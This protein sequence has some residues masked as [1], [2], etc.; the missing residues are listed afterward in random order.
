MA[1]QVVTTS[2]RNEATKGAQPAKLPPWTF[3]GGSSANA[4]Y[5]AFRA[6]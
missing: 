5:A 6:A 2:A 1:T 4:P 3:L